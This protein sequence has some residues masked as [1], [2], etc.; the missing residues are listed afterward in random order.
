MVV[1]INVTTHATIDVTIPSRSPRADR[2][3]HQGK[4]KKKGRRKIYRRPPVFL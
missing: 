2:Y 3:V 1:T 4:G